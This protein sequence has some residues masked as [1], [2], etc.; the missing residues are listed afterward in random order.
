[1]PKKLECKNYSSGLSRF[2]APLELKFASG[3]VS[4]EIEG[5]GAV[6]GNQDQHGDVIVPGAFSSSLEKHKSQGTMPAMHVSHD[7]ADGVGGAS[8]WPAGVWTEMREDEKGLRVRGKISAM[9]TEHSK[10]LYNLLQDGAFQGLSIAFSVPT[11]GSEKT[12]SKVGVKRALKTI[13]LYAVD[14]VTFPS[15]NL[16]RVD[17]VKSVL[18]I[19][20]HEAASEALAEALKLFVA[21]MSGGDS[22][23]V[24]ERA[25]MLKHLQDSHEALAG[26]RM[27]RGLK[28]RPTTIREFE[29]SLRDVGF[30]NA[31]AC[32]IAAHG[33]KSLTSR[34]ETNETKA[35]ENDT[36][37]KKVDPGVFVD[38]LKSIKVPTF[39]I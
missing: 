16:A 2:E 1:M 18:A 22:P 31:E 17:Q 19:A 36:N 7:W 24:E 20:D 13:D 38:L 11:G 21:T 10:R 8:A 9:D 14:I 6:F 37:I 33:F 26:R 4:G 27:P 23:T 32:A 34:D 15:N 25:Q 3:T 35:K 29:V 5:Y 30:S 39:S 28:A 12:K